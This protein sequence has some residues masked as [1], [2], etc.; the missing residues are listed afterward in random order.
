MM[1]R[2]GDAMAFLLHLVPPSL[3][4]QTAAEYISRHEFIQSIRTAWRA[5]Q[6]TVANNPLESTIAV[7]AVALLVWAVARMGS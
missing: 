5:L 7:L 4:T 1:D 2:G 6:R 3:L